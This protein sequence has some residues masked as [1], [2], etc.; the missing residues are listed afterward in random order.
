M[1]GEILETPG[2][3]EEVVNDPAQAAAAALAAGDAADDSDDDADGG[4]Q[5]GGD[6][7]IALKQERQKRQELAKEIA[8]LKPLAEE[9]QAVIPTVQALLQQQQLQARQ[10]QAQAQQNE[11]DQE[12]LAVAQDFGFETE[13]GKPDVARARRVIDRINRTTGRQ[14]QAAAAPANKAAAEANA[15]MV[16]ERAYKATGPDGNLYATREAIDQVFSQIPVEAL[17]NPDNVIA[18]LVMARGLGGPGQTPASEPVYSESPTARTSKVKRE[19]SGLDKSIAQMR[20]WD[21][22]KLSKVVAADDSY[23]TPLE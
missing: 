13:D 8:R 18:A 22:K 1:A 2:Q 9:Y 3:E 15:A 6:L 19:P 12:A 5:G 11:A 17:Q 4:E 14:A 7:R 16:K 10:Q 23:D 20:G 21:D